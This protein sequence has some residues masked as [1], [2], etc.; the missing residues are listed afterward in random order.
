MKAVIFNK[1][2]PGKLEYTDV[3]K[4]V[5]GDNDVLLKV[6]ATSLNAADYR[7]M[8]LGIVPGRKIFG[9]DVAGRVESVGKSVTQCRIYRCSRQ[10]I[11]EKT[12]RIIF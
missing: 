1:K 11:G 2:I 4:P 8:K 10:A 6:V 12:C 5:P 9:A 3:E 7:S